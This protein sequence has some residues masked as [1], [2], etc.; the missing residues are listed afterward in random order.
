MAGVRL[1]RP[2]ILFSLVLLIFIGM[3]F[4]IGIEQKKFDMNLLIFSFLSYWDGINK[5][6]E[7]I[8]ND[9]GTI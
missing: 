1:H 5:Y 3:I 7:N 6:L 2:A 9:W 4:F 8:K